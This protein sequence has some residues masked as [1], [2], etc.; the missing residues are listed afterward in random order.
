MQ[1]QGGNS[2]TVER[3][4]AL[5]ESLPT[6]NRG[7]DSG[8]SAAESCSSAVHEADRWYG[9]LAVEVARAM[10][11]SPWKGRWRGSTWVS[12]PLRCIS[13]ASLLESP[14]PLAKAQR[15]SRHRQRLHSRKQ[16]GSRNRRK[17]AAGLA[18]LRR[19]IRCRRT[20]FLHKAITGLVKTKSGT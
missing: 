4:S 8:G 13:D 7:Q 14:E 17:S 12:S 5:P 1:P 18:R 15:G 6:L 16:R 3:R 10:T 9:S 20:D 11:R 2:R 19:R